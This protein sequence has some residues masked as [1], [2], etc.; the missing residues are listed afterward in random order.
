MNDTNFISFTANKA[1]R[2]ILLDVF[3]YRIC[4]ARIALQILKDIEYRI[5]ACVIEVI[6]LLKDIV[7]VTEK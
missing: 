2:G 4:M 3:Y 7:N 6:P 1:L 5:K